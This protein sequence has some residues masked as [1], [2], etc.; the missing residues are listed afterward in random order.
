MLLP[1]GIQLELRQRD[2][3]E[4]RRASGNRVATM[5]GPD[6]ANDGE[7]ETIITSF[8]TNLCGLASLHTGRTDPVAETPYVRRDRSPPAC[9]C[10][11]RSE[12]RSQG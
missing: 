1:F 4:A 10:P 3:A 9:R 5:L 12:D 2:P 7:L 6:A 8:I 11:F